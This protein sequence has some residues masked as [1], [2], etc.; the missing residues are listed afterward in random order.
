MPGTGMNMLVPDA[1]SNARHQLSTFCAIDGHAVQ[2]FLQ[3]ED[4]PLSED[5]HLCIASLSCCSTLDIP[6]K[7]WPQALLGCFH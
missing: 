2:Y 1:T 7:L 4:T 5:T 6:L 3:P